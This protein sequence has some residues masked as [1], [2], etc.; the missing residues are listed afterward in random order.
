MSRKVEV[1]ECCG[2]K[3]V[4]YKHKLNKTLLSALWKLYYA[5]DQKGSLKELDLTHNEFANFQK[6]QYFGL[7]RKDRGSV[8]VMTDKGEDF[9]NRYGKAPSAVYTKNGVVV[10]KDEEIYINKVKGYIEVKEEWQEQASI[11]I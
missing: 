3:I 9:V 8:W 4:E 11:W 5:K 10:N 2:Q 6:L 7:V 1:C